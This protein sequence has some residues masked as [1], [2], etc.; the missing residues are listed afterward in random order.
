MIVSSTFAL[1]FTC[2]KAKRCSFCC[3]RERHR[4][5]QHQKKR[6]DV[7]S[8]SRKTW[9]W[10]EKKR[11]MFLLLQTRH[12]DNKNVCFNSK[13]L[14]FLCYYINSV[15]MYSFVKIVSHFKNDFLLLRKLHKKWVRM[16]FLKL[17][18]R[19]LMIIYLL[20]ALAFSST[21]VFMQIILR[22]ITIF[23]TL[24]NNCSRLV[25]IYS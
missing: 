16:P 19:S 25:Q 15:M 10:F 14:I 4:G 18:K 11:S 20:I 5:K 12:L 3:L 6:G 1:T 7:D 17:L 22:W 21:S 8:L 9:R 23:I 13:S 2:I 24:T